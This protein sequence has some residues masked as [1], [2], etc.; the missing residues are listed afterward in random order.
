[1]AIIELKN[2][3]VLN[4]GPPGVGKTVAAATISKQ[5]P[6]TLPAP[7]MTQLNDVFWCCADSHALDSLGGVNLR[8]NPANVFDIPQFLADRKAWAAEGMK[9]QPLFSQ[10]MSICLK[11]MHKWLQNN[12]SGNLVFDTLTAVNV[13]FMREFVVTETGSQFTLAK[14]GDSRKMFGF[15]KA[16]HD[17]LHQAV[18]ESLDFGV[19]I[20]LTHS[21]AVQDFVDASSDAGK[22]AKQARKAGKVLEE[23]SLTTSVWG[24]GL[25]NPKRDCMYMFPVLAIRAPG[26][27]QRKRFFLTIPSDS[28]EVK[29]KSEGILADK[30]EAN[31]RHIFEKVNKAEKK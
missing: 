12:P 14:A 22:A 6:R 25:D 28:W 24:A 16:A 4:Y 18:K 26:A 19:C 7:K 30:E 23:A 10:A 21:K 15:M 5:C 31:W 2:L 29:N 20:Y 3:F 17:M 8:V 11:K 9:N 13:G 27:K 1:M